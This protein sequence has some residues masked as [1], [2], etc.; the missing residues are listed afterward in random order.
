YDTILDWEALDSWMQRLDAA[1]L[2]AMDTETTSL[3][4]MQASLVGMSFSTE[5][6]RA[7]YIPLAHRGP[8]RVDQLPKAEVL[9]KMRSWLESPDAHKLL[10]NAKYDTHVLANEGIKLAGIVEDTM[11]QAYVLE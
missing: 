9:A 3:D 7:C 2:V 10:H 5:T 6:G 4:P 1:E 8:D 11:L